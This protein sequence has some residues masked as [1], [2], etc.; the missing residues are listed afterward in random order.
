MPDNATLRE[1][2]RNGETLQVGGAPMDATKDE[3]AEILKQG[4]YDMIGVCS[5][6]GPFDEKK[7]CGHSV[8]LRMNSEYR[9]SYVSRILNTPISSEIC[10]TWVPPPL[11]FRS[12]KRRMTWMKPS[13]RF[14]IRPW[15]SE[16]SHRLTATVGTS[17]LNVKNI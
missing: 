11:S 10:V 15:A 12:L 6:H 7:N 17:I 13:A 4:S 14:T 5:Q 9:F 1:R 3:L 8:R 16:V 2:I